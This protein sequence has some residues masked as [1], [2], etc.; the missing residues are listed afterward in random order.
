MDMETSAFVDN[1]YSANYS[2]VLQDVCNQ[3]ESEITSKEAHMFCK[4]SYDS[5]YPQV[6]ANVCQEWEK[7]ANVTLPPISDPSAISNAITVLRNA[8]NRDAFGKP[9]NISTLSQAQRARMPVFAP[10]AMSLVRDPIRAGLGYASAGWNMI[11]ENVRIGL[12]LGA[13]G[14]GAGYVAHRANRKEHPVG[15][16]Y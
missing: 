3:W 5:L 12:N 4:D 10:E 16:M 14:L 9:T 11:P 2:S 1:I 6:L 8:M 13:A 15:H 7:S